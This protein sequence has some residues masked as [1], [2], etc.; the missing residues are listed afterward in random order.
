MVFRGF[1]LYSTMFLAVVVISIYEHCI[2]AVI[3]SSDDVGLAR[4]IFDYA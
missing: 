2:N 1:K 4:C 3:L